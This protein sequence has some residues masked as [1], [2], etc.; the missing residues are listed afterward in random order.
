MSGSYTVVLF[1]NG[2]VTVTATGTAL[3]PPKDTLENR[4]IP[5]FKA[6]IVFQEL[7]KTFIKQTLA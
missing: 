1:T 6:S 4:S 7:M 5:N 2:F 3:I